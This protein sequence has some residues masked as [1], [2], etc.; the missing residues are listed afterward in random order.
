MHEQQHEP[1]IATKLVTDLHEKITFLERELADAAMEEIRLHDII[2]SLSKKIQKLEK[3]ELTP[4]TPAP[5]KY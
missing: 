3:K 5:Y 2:V 1:I 4:S